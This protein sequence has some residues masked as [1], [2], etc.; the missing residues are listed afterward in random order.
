[1]HLHTSFGGVLKAKQ[2]LRRQNT[3]FIQFTCLRRWLQNLLD[4]KSH[5]ACLLK[6]QLPGA[7]NL[8]KKKKI[9]KTPQYSNDQQF[10]KIFLNV[11]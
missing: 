5:L 9:Q 6:I 8:K 11:F 4:F 1:M 10:L 7:L 2:K 3:L